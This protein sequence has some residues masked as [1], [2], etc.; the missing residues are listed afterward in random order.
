ML[1]FHEMPFIMCFSRNPPQISDRW[2]FQRSVGSNKCSCPGEKVTVDASELKTNGHGYGTFSSGLNSKA[3][4]PVTTNE[5]LD[6]GPPC[7]L[8]CVCESLSCVRLFAV[9]PRTPG[10]LDSWCP[11]S[12][13]G[14]SVHGISPGQEYWSGLPFVSVGGDLSNPTRPPGKLD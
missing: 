14:S 7:D 11:G 6:Q 1:D 2:L 8:V 13:P 4:F 10:V 12:L 5:G 3:L 9:T